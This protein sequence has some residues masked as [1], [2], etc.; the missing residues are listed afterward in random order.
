MRSLRS[1]SLLTILCAPLATM[2]PPQRP[3]VQGIALVRLRVSD[4]KSA[5]HF[6]HETLGLYPLNSAGGTATGATEDKTVYFLNQDQRVELVPGVPSGDANAIDVVG[7][8][9]SNVKQIRK[10]LQARG[11][12][13]EA[14]QKTKSGDEYVE[15]LDPENHHVWFVSWARRTDPLPGFT[16]TEHMIHTGFI[17]R[18]RAAE[19]RFYKDLLG[20]HLYWQGGRTEGETLW[21]AMQ[22]PDGTDWLEYMLNIPA[23]PDAHTRG[24][25]DHI[26]IGTEDIHQKNKQMVANGWKPTEEPKIGLDGKWQLNL[27]DPDQTRV[28][29][30]EFTPVQKPCCSPFVGPQPGPKN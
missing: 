25:Q 20:F 1:I 2:A 18:D 27:Y 15:T 29:F 19:D 24:V 13:C 16:H 12:K 7:F 8:Q 26:S 21:A 17:V 3:E 6:Y 5:Q 9:V 10:Y 30:M 11:Q 4:M 23:N 22:V 28:E 14:T